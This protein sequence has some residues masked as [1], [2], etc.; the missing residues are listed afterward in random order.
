MASNEENPEVCEYNITVLQQL[1]ADKSETNLST[2]AQ[3]LHPQYFEE[4]FERL[5]AQTIL[6]E[7]RYIDRDYLEDFS[8][9]YVRCFASY[10]RFCTRLHFF[11]CS[12]T[13]DEINDLLQN[14]ENA[15]LSLEAL[16]DDYLGFIVVK[17][18]PKTVVGR[19][20]LKTY[21]SEKQRYFPAIRE[22]FA[23]PFG[24]RLKVKSLAFQEQDQITAA[25]ATSALWSAFHGTGKHFQH[26]LPSPIEITRLATQD[27]LFST[28]VLPN[29]G[30]GSLHMARAIK[31][32]G[33]EPYYV[34]VPDL[35]V[36]K[37]IVYAYLRGG[38]PAI[39]G[40]Q[41]WNCAN[42]PCRFIDRHAV[43][44]SGYRLANAA[45]NSLAF[46]TRASKITKIYVH[47]DQVGPFARMEFD[48]RVVTLPNNTSTVSKAETLSTSFTSGSGEIGSTRAVPEL[49]I[50]PL[51]HK[52]R[53]PYATVRQIV[54]WL[55]SIIRW[56]EIPLP[57]DEWDVYLTTINEMKAELLSARGNNMPGEYRAE[58]LCESLP[59]FLWRA[60][61]HRGGKKLFDLLFDATDIA[62]GSI[63]IRAIEW[64]ENAARSLRKISA[65]DGLEQYDTTETQVGRKIIAWFREQ[66][67]LEAA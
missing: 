21:P 43:A 34:K 7:N 2:I 22:Y 66:A 15:A 13:K 58:L 28:R 32:I 20:C 16:N 10:K 1:I 33:L 48:G 26:T 38:V 47:D 67:S 56:T 49:L 12:F 23:H 6:V 3:R 64:D 45:P 65:I 61:A 51:Y 14:S 19:T 54:H 57:I 52:I 59:R 62:Q 63:F 42:Q 11:S 35:G 4:Y 37:E 30:L 39:L 8:A 60:C 17:P 46:T 41:L 9:Y 27:N 53:I 25:C 18:L 50:V 5:K 24:M 55:N 29:K 31:S 36:L 44:V 40:V